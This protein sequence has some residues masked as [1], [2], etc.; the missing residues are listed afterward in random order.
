MSSSNSNAA[1]RRRRAGP[2]VPPP[3]SS[4]AAR[5][6]QPP[7]QIQQQKN[8]QPQ[9]M[10]N[11]NSTQQTPRPVLTPAQMLI[12]HENRITE[13]EKVIPEIMQNFEMNEDEPLVSDND[14]TIGTQ[15]SE[16]FQTVE[17]KNEMLESRVKNLEDQLENMMKSYNLLRDFAT[18]TNLLVMK[19]FNSD[20]MEMTMNNDNSN[21]D[22]KINLILDTT[23]NISETNN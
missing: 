6:S 20:N 3:M 23:N 1:A 12:A 15:V 5:A 19:I 10:T 13:L 22:D 14:D 17:T 16:R 2:S 9:Q 7:P 4:L 18:E 8:N 11:P 21:I